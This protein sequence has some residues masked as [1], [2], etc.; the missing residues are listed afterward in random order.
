[1]LEPS[2]IRL[3]PELFRVLGEHLGGDGFPAE[4]R[5]TDLDFVPAVAWRFRLE[6]IS[7]MCEPVEMEENFTRLDSETDADC[8]GF[9][10]GVVNA[11]PGFPGHLPH[12]LTEQAGRRVIDFIEDPLF[13]VMGGFL[14]CSFNQTETGIGGR[15]VL[16]LKK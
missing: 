14:N 9:G 11:L 12:L 15:G 3:A 7:V 13:P 6:L 1:M 5:V 8:I 10:Y 4:E 2:Q 16:T